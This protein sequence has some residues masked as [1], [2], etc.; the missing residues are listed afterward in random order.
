MRAENRDKLQLS[1][2]VPH[3]TEQGPFVESVVSL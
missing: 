3:V 2:F 1:G